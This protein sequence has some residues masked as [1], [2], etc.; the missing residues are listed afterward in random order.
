MAHRGDEIR[1][2]RKWKYVSF[3]APKGGGKTTLAMT[4]P[5]TKLVLQ[6]DLG[7]TSIP[8]GVDPKS[9]YVQTYPDSDHSGLKKDSDKWTRGKK[10]YGE[11]ITDIDNVI[12]AFEKKASEVV[13]HD[14]TKVPLPEVLI[15][16]GLVRLDNII[17]D[18]FCAINNISDPGDALDSKGKVGGGVQKFWGRRLS[19]INKLF[20]LAVSL[21]IHVAALTWESIYELKDAQ[22]NVVSRKRTPD[23]GGRLDVW[24]P[25]MF[26]GCIY[27]YSEA[28]R[29]YVRTQSTGEIERLGIRDCYNALPVYDV[30]IDSAKPGEPLPFEKVFGKLISGGGK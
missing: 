1:V 12:T 27:Q 17:V 5:G 7:S 8:P 30:T 24:G 26:D 15:L 3:G 6:Y 16:D 4:A 13:M 14:G 2:E 28:G 22:G 9:V 20:G 10:V 25:G 23:I 18:G 29:F 19:N 21:P 11:V